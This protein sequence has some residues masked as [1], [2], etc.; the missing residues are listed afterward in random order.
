[1]DQTHPLEER[2]NRFTARWRRLLWVRGLAAS[3][4]WGV[5]LL[6]AAALCDYL[7]RS[8][9]ATVR[10][11]LAAVAAIGTSAAVYRFL[12][13]PLRGDWSPATAAAAI[14]QR[15]PELR[16]R[17]LA[18]VEF[19]SA[20]ADD[21]HGGSEALRRA[22]VEDAAAAAARFE[23]NDLL[24][25]RPMIRAVGLFAAA[26]AAVLFA[27]LLWPRTAAVAALRLLQPWAGPAWPRQ[28]ELRLGPIPSRVARGETIE[29]EITAASGTRLPRSLRVWIRDRGEETAGSEYGEWLS[30]AG[31]SAV[32]RRANVQHSFAFRVEGG[33]DRSMPWREVDVVAPVQIVSLS[34]RLD[35]PEYSRL[36]S[37]EATA[38]VRTLAGTA[39]RVSATVDRPVSSAALFWPGAGPIAAAI[40]ASG[41]RLS[42]PAGGGALRVRE[43]NRA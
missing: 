8:D 10:V 18:A 31:D 32:W 7:W 1:M 40:D 5:A 41:L 21:S 27:A 33:D 30:V 36:P 35:P 14:E 17:L 9:D 42:F 25:R 39:V 13:L 3:A 24:D 29:V 16:N 34:L 15:I 6:T 28:T 43:R 23:W 4:G 11:L 38:M 12:Y 2:L 20:R 26:A 37:T 19:L 22:V